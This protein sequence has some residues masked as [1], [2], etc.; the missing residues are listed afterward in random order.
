MLFAVPPQRAF[1]YL[2]DPRN[3]PAW[4]SSLRRVEDLRPG[5]DGAPSGA[6][7]TWTDVTA[8][9]G[10]RP[11]MR[12]E[13]SEAP[14]HWAE[15]GTWGPVT[16]RLTL[17]LEPTE[18]GTLVHVD[19]AVRAPGVGRLLSTLARRPVR[20]DLVRAARLVAAG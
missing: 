11:R 4:Q 20:A 2:A 18:G 16:A 1:A 17:T 19:L 9:P 3:R 13:R 8:V 15:V 14:R 10:V 6:G 7:A 5:P 12:T